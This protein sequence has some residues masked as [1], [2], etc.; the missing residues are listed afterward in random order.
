MLQDWF[1]G[2]WD[3]V[4]SINLGF[5]GVLAIAGWARPV[6]L[7]WAALVLTLG[8]QGYFLANLSYST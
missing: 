6:W 8:M 7:Q 2:R 5:I 1:G 3:A 4:T